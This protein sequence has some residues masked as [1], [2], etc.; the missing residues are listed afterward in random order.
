MHCTKWGELVLQ[1]PVIMN[2]RE[3]LECSLVG[4]KLMANCGFTKSLFKLNIW[5]LATCSQVGLCGH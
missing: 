5:G 1:V 4:D 3:D 2:W